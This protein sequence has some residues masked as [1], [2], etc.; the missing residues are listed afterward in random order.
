MVMDDFRLGTPVICPN[1]GHEDLVR[2][3][4]YVKLKNIF[5]INCGHRGLKRNTDYDK[6]MRKKKD[7]KL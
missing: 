6:E 5:C 3:K 4:R 7:I 1:C 2:L